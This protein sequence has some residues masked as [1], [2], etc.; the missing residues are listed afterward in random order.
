MYATLSKLKGR[1]EEFGDGDEQGTSRTAAPL[2]CPHRAACAERYNDAYAAQT[3]TCA[4]SW[5]RSVTALSARRRCSLLC[6]TFALRGQTICAHSRGQYAKGDF[7]DTYVPTVFE[8]YTASLDHNGK[9][10][11]LHLWDTAGQE[12]YGAM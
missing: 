5:S 10:V 8:N 1:V 11:L 4:S 7:P 6:A 9:K 2:L 12:D 3:A